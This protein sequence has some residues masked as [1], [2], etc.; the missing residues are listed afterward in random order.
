MGQQMGFDPNMFGP[1]GAM[2]QSY[3]S[4]FGA[5]TPIS[6]AVATPGFDLNAATSQAAAP[7]KAI[8]RCQLEVLGFVNRRAQAYMQVPARLAQCRT[9]QDVLDEQ[10]AF[11]RTA[12]E[13]YNEGAR[14]M[15]EAWTQLVP[16]FSAAGPGNGSRRTERDYINFNGTGSRESA[17]AQGPEPRGP[18]RRVA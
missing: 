9:P 11:W 15:V 4:A 10:I 13:Q 2:W 12:G 3:L 1:F 5:A 18:Q 7:L 8:A 6:E 17:G 14:R 16:A